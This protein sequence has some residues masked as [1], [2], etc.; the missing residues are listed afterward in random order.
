VRSNST[1]RV[2]GRERRKLR[3]QRRDPLVEQVDHG[4]RFGDRAP[5]SFLDPARGEQLHRIGGTQPL[6]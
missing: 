2:G 5:P 6:Q 3:S 1:R 4:Q